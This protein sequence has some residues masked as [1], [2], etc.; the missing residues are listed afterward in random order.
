MRLILVCPM[1]LPPSQRFAALVYIEIRQMIGGRYLPGSSITAGID[2]DCE[3]VF[4]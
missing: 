4:G 3:R 1:V 2:H